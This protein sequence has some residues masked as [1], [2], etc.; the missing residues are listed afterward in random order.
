MA[1]LIS[2]RIWNGCRF[3]LTL[4]FLFH[5]WRPV[6]YTTSQKKGFVNVRLLIGRESWKWRRSEKKLRK[7][8]NWVTS[9]EDIMS[10]ATTIKKTEEKEEKQKNK[11][12]VLTFIA[13][14]TAV[15]SVWLWVSAHAAKFRIHLVRCVVVRVK[16]FSILFFLLCCEFSFLIKTNG[17]FFPFV[18]L[19]SNYVPN[20]DE[21]VQ[22][23]LFS[24][25][26]KREKKT[27]HHFDFNSREWCNNSFLIQT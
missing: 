9:D 13:R 10:T 14:H 22:F 4:C 23:T 26:K 18:R 2:F 19:F 15:S 7:R 8:C 20:G 3:Y 21:G 16:F 11:K 24:D 5:F 27:F 17:V 25:V 1:A 12:N 6:R